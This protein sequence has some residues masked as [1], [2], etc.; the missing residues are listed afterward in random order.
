MTA[1]SD[2][3]ARKFV[4]DWIDLNVRPDRTRDN[5]G[6]AIAEL[7]ERCLKEAA[8]A[9]ISSLDIEA[10]TGQHVSDLIVAAYLVRWMPEIGRGGSA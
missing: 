5:V 4:A 1:A 3:P 2:R 10:E 9:G 7:I 6:A 8:E